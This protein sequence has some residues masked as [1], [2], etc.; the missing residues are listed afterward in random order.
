MAA[1]EPRPRCSNFKQ[2]KMEP[3]SVNM[4]KMHCYYASDSLL[5]LETGVFVTLCVEHVTTYTLRTSVRLIY[6]FSE[7]LTSGLKH[8]FRSTIVFDYV[9]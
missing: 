9:N 3:Q 8:P 1:R 7:V 2:L 4:N 5:I 6:I